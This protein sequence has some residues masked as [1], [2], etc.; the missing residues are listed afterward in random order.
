MAPYLRR[1]LLAT[2]QFVVK[3]PNRTSLTVAERLHKETSSLCRQSVAPSLTH[4][5]PVSLTYAA[6]TSS[7]TPYERPM[8][9]L[10]CQKL[11][12]LLCQK[13]SV[14][15]YQNLTTTSISVPSVL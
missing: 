15:I 8:P 4:K 11:L 9:I 14:F 13:L 2:L 3:S 5:T 7:R 12:I 6:N 10:N 1:R